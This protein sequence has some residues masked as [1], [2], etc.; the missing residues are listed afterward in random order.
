[1]TINVLTKVLFV[2]D[3]TWQNFAVLASISAAGAFRLERPI[4]PLT[5]KNLTVATLINTLGKTVPL[6]EELCLHLL[7]ECGGGHG[8]NPSGTNVV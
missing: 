6:S 7:G 1:L 4:L 5:N 2:N 3:D 8:E